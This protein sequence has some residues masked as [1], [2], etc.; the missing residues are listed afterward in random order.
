[1]FRINSGQ[2]ADV[3]QRIALLQSTS[4]L[5]KA[6]VQRLPDIKRSVKEQQEDISLLKNKIYKQIG[7]V[8]TANIKT[9]LLLNQKST[10][11]KML[12]AGDVQVCI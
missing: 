9:N 11:S 7:G 2:F 12:P 3:R 8:H 4:N 5:F 1:M 6:E 10:K